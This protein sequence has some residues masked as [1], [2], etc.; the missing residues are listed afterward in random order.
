MEKAVELAAVALIAVICGTVLRRGVSALAVVL[1]LT[2]GAVLL[3]ALSDELAELKDRV[4][5][6]MQ[7]AGLDLTL[8]GPV[9]Q[10][11]AIAVVTRVASEICRDAKES[12]IA[13]VLE[14]A[15]TVLVLITALPLME[16]VL[17]GIGGIL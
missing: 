14:L 7:S 11:V 9:L 1:S 4:L 5:G 13:A 17:E 6:M 3:A 12:G 2:A 15:G 8:M 16:L 10:A